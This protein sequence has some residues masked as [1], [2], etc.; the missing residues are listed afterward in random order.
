MF[1]PTFLMREIRLLL[2]L[3]AFFLFLGAFTYRAALPGRNI[4]FPRDH[5]SHPDF[6]TEWWYYTGHLATESGKQFGYQVTFFRFG[7][8]D[9][10]KGVESPL[11]TDLYMAHF[12]LSDK[13]EKSFYFTERADRGFKGKAG[14]SVD[15]YLVWIE[16]WKVEE[17]GSVHTIR[18][19]DRDKALRLR[20]TPLKAPVLHGQEG[21]SKKGEGRGRASYYYSFTR[22]ETEGEL[23]IGNKAEKVRGITWMDHEFGS[24]QLSENQ[25]G[26]DW[27]S[28]QLDNETEIMLYLL[29]WKDGSPDSYSSGTFVYPDGSLRHLKLDDF[30]VEIMDTWKSPKSGGLYPMGW[31]ILIPSERV[32]LEL[33]PYFKD[34]ELRTG[35]S[36]RVNYWEG[37]VRVKGSYRNQPVK[38]LGY[39]EMTGYTEKMRF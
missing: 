4:V 28:L 25:V 12:A 10:Q 35:K 24:N 22:L 18:V 6:Q 32:A 15:R 1:L 23:E 37:A 34:Q 21:L 5:A 39:V 8:R 27:F 19:R 7:L 16:D 36:T 13:K 2:G 9:R 26:W 14:A 33:Q 3:L 30:R 38:G 20:L 11:F 29:R 17:E 31:K